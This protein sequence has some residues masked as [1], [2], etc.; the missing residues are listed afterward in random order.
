[1]PDPVT[2]ELAAL[3]Q[4][5]LARLERERQARKQAEQL[6]EEKS[7]ELYNS[8]MKLRT[9]AENLENLVSERTEEL[10]EALVQAQ[11][12]TAAKSEFLATMSHEI[13]TPMNGILGM[14]ELLLDTPLSEEQQN[15]AFVIKNCSQTLLAII[16]DILDFSKIEAGKL[17]LEHIPFSPQRFV[18][19]L[20]EVFQSQTRDKKLAMQVLLDSKLPN[21]LMGD[22]TRLRQIL[23]NLLSNAIKFTHAGHICV[24]LK[25]LELLDMYQVSVSDT[26][27]GISKDAQAKLFSAF[28]QAD[29]KTSREYGGTGLGLA[30]CA[31]M[32]QLMGGRIWV[33][34]EPGK[35]SQ[36]YFTFHASLGEDKGANQHQSQTR[37]TLA[38]LR[39]LLVE[40]NKINRKVAIKLLEKVSIKPDIATDGLEALKLVESNSYDVILMDMQ[41]PN[42]D[43]LTATQHI[44]EMTKIHQPFIV[45]LTANA[46]NENKQACKEAGMNDFLSKPIESQKLF[47]ILALHDSHIVTSS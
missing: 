44:R 35:G 19:E 31:R 1:M 20:L 13:R 15:F 12:A 37:P 8:N 5:L 43:G 4:R 26:G 2:D 40:D 3:E 46:F 21:T 9:L 10:A 33:E 25:A 24:E 42:M 17:E 16:N 30:I 18:N 23:F 47:D 11:K 7:L 22:P 28:S 6:L 45:A 29:S 38:H 34:S 39:L 32:T 14:T 41:M 27:I 36:F